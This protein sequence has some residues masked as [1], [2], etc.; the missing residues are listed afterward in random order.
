MN[1]RRNDDNWLDLFCRLF[2]RHHHPKPKPTVI[3]NFGAF[4]ITFRGDFKMNLPSGMQVVATVAWDNPPQSPPVWA[5][6]SSAVSVAPD[7]DSAVIAYVSPGTANITATATNPDGT[8][9][10]A[11]G[12]IEAAGASV[13]NTTSGTMSFGTPTPIGGVVSP[14]LPSSFPDIQAF[15]DVVAAYS[16]PE[17]ITLDGAEV[18][19]G[20]SPALAYV[21]NNDGSIVKA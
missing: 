21:T 2:C 5:S 9:A 6:D 14:S 10:V 20:T 7:G 4:S 16:G 12:V 3:I 17:S 19:T 1:N 15:A 11:K 13:P 8:K 18:R